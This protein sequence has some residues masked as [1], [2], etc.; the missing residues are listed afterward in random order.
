MALSGKSDVRSLEARIAALESALREQVDIQS[1]QATSDRWSRGFVPQ[2]QGVELVR[3]EAGLMLS[4]TAATIPD[5]RYYELEYARKPNFG[6][7]TRVR[8]TDPF[9]FFTAGYGMPGFYFYVRAR[10]VSDERRPGPWTAK[11]ESAP[12]GRS[13]IAPVS[14]VLT[15]PRRPDAIVVGGTSASSIV[16]I[17]GGWVGRCIT[18]FFLV[19]HTVTDSSRIRLAGNFTATVSSSLTLRFMGD[20]YEWVEVSRT[21]TI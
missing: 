16:R 10:L 13:S 11:L 8:T 7:V 3:S 4:W 5:L 20:P 12:P 9:H 6:S 21:G 19:G 17:D 2:L 18:L 15:L 1:R 14:G